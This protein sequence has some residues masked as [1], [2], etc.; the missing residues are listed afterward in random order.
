[1]GFGGIA[2]RTGYLVDH[3][4]VLVG[5]RWDPFGIPVSD[6]FLVRFLCVFCCYSEGIFVTFWW[7]PSDPDRSPHKNSRQKFLMNNFYL[8][9]RAL[10]GGLTVVFSPVKEDLNPQCI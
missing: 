7:G 6:W 5:F 1:M 4:G 9:L 2:S 3:V 10:A 8:I